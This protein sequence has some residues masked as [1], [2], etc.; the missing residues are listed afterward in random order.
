MQSTE[1]IVAKAAVLLSDRFGGNQTLT[2]IETLNGSGNAQVLRVRV[3]TNP[4][5]QERSVVV[6]YIPITDDELDDAALVR[7]VVAYQFTTALSEDERPGPV[8]L[9]HDIAQRILVISDSGNGDTFAELLERGDTQQRIH[10]LR[11]LGQ[12][13]GRMHRATANKE[14]DFETLRLRMAK[15]H[16]AAAR[17]N[18]FRLVMQDYSMRT[19]YQKLLEAGIAVPDTVA[20]MLKESM[21]SSNVAH[22]AFSPFDLSPDNI[23][24]AQRTQF[25]D[26]EWAC[27]RNILLDIAAV[28][29]GFP[30]YLFAKAISDDEVDILIDAWE[31]ETSELWPEFRDDNA[32]QLAIGR[33]LLALAVS[34]LTLMHLGGSHNVVAAIAADAAVGEDSITLNPEE[35]TPLQHLL[36][37]P[38]STEFSEGELLMRQDLLETFSALARYASRS[39]NNKLAVVAEFATDIATRLAD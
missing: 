22:R 17:V 20:L 33:A 12:S 10:I 8:L 19:G 29:A 27:F 1:E 23:I 37:L 30:H 28:I 15:K 39:G 9:A 38:N 13:L 34:E 4:Y 18:R 21:D 25:L 26:Y 36:A 7:E 5:L 14:T 2:D 24:V 3:A 31:R 16:P 6:K 11:N 35:I 32:R